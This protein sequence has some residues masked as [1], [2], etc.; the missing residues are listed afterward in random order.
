MKKVISLALVLCMVFMFAA[1]GGEKAPEANTGVN[2]NAS[3]EPAHSFTVN[4]TKI[5]VGADATDILAA[6]GEPKTR[7]EEASCAFEGKDVTYYYGNFYLTTYPNGDK[8]NVF[9][10]WFVDDS[11]TTEEGIYI[12]A[13]K[14]EV[15]N[16]YGADTFNGTNAYVITKGQ[17]K[18]TVILKDDVVSQITYDLIVD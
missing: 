9:S 15:E 5:E 12:G 8:E 2:T 17:S 11:L 6:M 7:T 1:C 13:S 16:A 14:A 3:T 10:A 18:L 4:G